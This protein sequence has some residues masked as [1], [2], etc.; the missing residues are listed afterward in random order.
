[1]V[2]E[3]LA[4]HRDPHSRPQHGHLLELV[5]RGAATTSALVDLTPPADPVFNI[6][7]LNQSDATVDA[8]NLEITLRE[9]LDGNGW[10]DGA[11]DSVQTVV[12]FTS[13]EFD[14]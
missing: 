13:S 10:T 3:R 1:M 6:W 14:D 4:E 8:Y 5:A 12:S 9:D 7:V 2:F 11:E